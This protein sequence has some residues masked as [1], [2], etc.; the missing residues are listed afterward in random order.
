[1]KSGNFSKSLHSGIRC[2]RHY[3]VIVWDVLQFQQHS[4][5]I[6]ATIKDFGENKNMFAYIRKILRFLRNNAN[7][8]ICKILKTQSDIIVD[9]GSS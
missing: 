7:M 3:P 9:L 4:V 6:L 5:K 8:T 1:M 2:R